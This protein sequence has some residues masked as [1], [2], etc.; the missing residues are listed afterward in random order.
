M[1]DNQRTNLV[2]SFSPTNSLPTNVPAGSYDYSFGA[3]PVRDFVRIGV[4]KDRLA[5]IDLDGTNDLTTAASP[6]V[7][8]INDDNDA[9]DGTISDYVDDN[10]AS[11]YSWNRIV[12][13]RDLEDFERLAIRFPSFA[14]YDATAT[15]SLRLTAPTSLKFFAAANGSRDHVESLATATQLTQ[16]FIP[17]GQPGC[18]LGEANPTLTLPDWVANQALQNLAT[19][20]CLFEAGTAGTGA[21]QVEL[22][23]NGDV[24]GRAKVFL[25][26]RPI[27]EM[28]DHYTAGDTTA[29]GATVASTAQQIGACQLTGLDDDYILFVHGW[30]MQEWERRRFAETAFK[31]LWW[32]GYKGRFGLFSWPTEYSPVPFPPVNFQRSELQAWRSGEPLRKLL[33][34]LNAGVHHDHVRVFAHS[35]GNVACGEAFRQLTQAGYTNEV[36]TYAAMQGAL[37]SH[38]YDFFAPVR[39]LSAADSGTRNL[40]AEYPTPYP[41]GQPYLNGVRGARHFWNFLNRDDFA[42][43]MWKLNQDLKPGSAVD[44]D[45]QWTQAHDFFVGWVGQGPQPPETVTRQ[46]YSVPDRYEIFAGA[47]EARCWAIGAQPGLGGAF[48]GEVDLQSAGF[49]FS[50]PASHHSGQFNSTI[51]LRIPVWKELK[52]KFDLP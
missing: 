37:A 5:G 41:S 11:T 6:H 24:V 21:L 51:Q 52:E 18:Y 22:L 42:L 49:D 27:T 2:F 17:Q 44:G 30:R 46:L 1:Q 8:W 19:I 14:Y 13:P 4:D 20:Y 3:W 16:Q 50:S 9:Y 43:N 40:F 26:L 38:C 35:M 47:A 39:T 36:H 12:N 23:R 29:Q 48:E 28:Y 32:A 15:W 45:Y 31:R 10:G 25:K 7:F 33:K 34:S